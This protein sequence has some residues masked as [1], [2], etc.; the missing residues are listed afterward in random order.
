MTEQ[1]TA[2]VVIKGIK[3]GILVELSPTE[4][5]LDVTGELARQ[6]DARS[7]FFTGS[8]ITVDLGTRPVPRH[9]LTSLKALLERRGLAIWSI[10]SDSETTIEAAHVLD[11][12]TN[13]AN[14]VPTPKP[15]AAVASS[16][17]QVDDEGAGGTVVKRTLRSGQLIR[18]EGHVVVVGDVNP[19]AKIVAGGDIIVWG[20]LRGVVHAGAEGDESVVVCALDMSPTQLR[21]AGYIVT[22]PDDN[23]QR[24]KP[25]PEVAS[26]RDAQIVVEA[27]R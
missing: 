12:K 22:S 2:N 11:L 24:R 9:E 23:N 27:W 15:A 1:T 21:I 14:T 4:A 5:W 25:Q 8:N 16:Q 26:I 3:N 13:V 17:P 6:I 19:G 7:S 20:R 18:S 10:M